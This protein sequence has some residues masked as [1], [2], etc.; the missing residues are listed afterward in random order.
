[1]EPIVVTA[2][3]Q[4][5]L[6][7]ASTA[8]LVPPERCPEGGCPV[9]FAYGYQVV[10]EPATESSLIAASE[11]DQPPFHASGNQRQEPFGLDHGFTA[12]A[13]PGRYDIWFD[14]TKGL[15]CGSAA[16]DAEQA[17]AT[18]HNVATIEVK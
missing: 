4:L 17:S 5:R 11:C 3:S 15:A 18:R 8:D 10:N 6:V 16:P 1:M 9:R 7:L 14:F 13:K 2:G 12:P